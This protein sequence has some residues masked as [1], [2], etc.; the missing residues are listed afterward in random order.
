MLSPL[1]TLSY[2]LLVFELVSATQI[3]PETKRDLTNGERLARG[4]PVK[5][6][7]R[8][9]NATQTHAAKSKRS[10]SPGVAYIRASPVAP[11]KAKRASTPFDSVSYVCKPGSFYSLCNDPSQA[12]QFTYSGT[13]TG[14]MLVDNAYSSYH[15]CSM[16]WDTDTTPYNMEDGQ[17]Q[18]HTSTC[19]GLTSTSSQTYAA[20]HGSFDQLPIFNVPSSGLGEMTFTFYNADGTQTDDGRWFVF[21]T[22]YSSNYLGG[23][24]DPAD[25]GAS[26]T[27]ELTLTLVSSAT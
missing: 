16:I 13:G 11:S 24:I 27:A 3:P 2:A 20:A 8:R 5:N 19:F 9:F 26:S 22:P 12:R 6:P 25:L 15:V 17:G 14:M 21:S 7:D 18:A 4:F 23:A 1:S 10:G